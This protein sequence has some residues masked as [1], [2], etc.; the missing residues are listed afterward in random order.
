MRVVKVENVVKI[1]HVN[2]ELSKSI[3][4]KDSNHYFMHCDDVRV[5]F[6]RTTAMTDQEDE[7]FLI[8]LI[9]IAVFV[10]Y[11]LSST[12]RMQL[13]YKRYALLKQHPSV[14]LSRTVC[15]KVAFRFSSP[16]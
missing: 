8:Q 4:Y 14:I 16:A 12:R 15:N 9:V 7:K 1:F 2:Q 11:T 5:G 6:L 10:Y 3:V 13:Q